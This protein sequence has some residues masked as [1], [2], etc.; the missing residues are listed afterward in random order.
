[1]IHDVDARTDGVPQRSLDALTWDDA[2]SGV[3]SR[4]F[5]DQ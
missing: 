1:M 2:Q 5:D 4:S 3:V